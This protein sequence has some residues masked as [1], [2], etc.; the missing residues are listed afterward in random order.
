MMKDKDAAEKYKNIAMKEHI[1]PT[2]KEIL[3][4]PHFVM[5]NMC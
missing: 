1:G 2:E 5:I 3:K 4:D